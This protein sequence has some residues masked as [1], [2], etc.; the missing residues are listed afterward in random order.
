MINENFVLTVDNVFTKK[1]CKKLMNLYNTSDNF[2]SEHGGIYT[3]S[4]GS[5]GYHFVDINVNSFLYN[6]KINQI[7]DLY[8]KKYPEINMTSSYW[9]LTTL[10]FKFFKKGDSFNNWHCEH[11]LVHPNRILGIQI[12]LTE[13]DCGTEFYNKKTIL[14]KIGRVCIFPAF[15]THIHR[16]QADL[17]KNRMIITG[18]FNFIKLGPHDKNKEKHN[19]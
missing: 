18:Y 6:H 5:I 1:E 16:G 8:I 10:R 14:S 3:N 19:D 11:S 9:A 12:Y 17:L 13:H 4:D 15:F 2:K 7:L